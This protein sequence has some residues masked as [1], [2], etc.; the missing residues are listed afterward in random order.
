MFSRRKARLFVF[1]A[2]AATVG[3]GL[4]I[5]VTPASTKINPAPIFDRPGIIDSAM[6]RSWGEDLSADAV[7]AAGIETDLDGNA[8]ALLASDWYAKR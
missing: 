5:Y 7:D 3:G 4:F 6:F 2:V 1:T 8:L